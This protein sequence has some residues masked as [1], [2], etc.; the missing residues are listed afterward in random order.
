MN[1]EIV[2][3]GS[4]RGARNIIAGQIEE[5]TGLSTFNL[6]YPGSDIEFQE[7]L[8]RSLIHFNETPQ[9][10]L[11]AIDD[12]RQFLPSDLLIFRLERLYPLARYPYINKEM[13]ARGEKNISSKTLV[14]ARMNIRNFDIRRKSFT[15][16]DTITEYGS[17]P[18]YS[19]NENLTFNYDSLIHRYQ[20][21]NEL[22]YKVNSFLK[23]QK[24]CEENNIELTLVFSPNFKAHNYSFERR[25]KQ[26]THDNV[27]FI[28]YDSLNPIY[29]DE[30]YFYDNFH[31]RSAGAI[32]FTNEIVDF[33][34]SE[35]T[36]QLI[37]TN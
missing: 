2:I 35:K 14:L 15:Y 27:D 4:S 28:L 9:K 16:L 17:M 6:S 32:T 31:L 19:Q 29:K 21:N 13:I 23:I 1:K 3:L 12:P 33:L 5:A 34:E 30:A 24:I 22:E 18:I 25:M 11:L 20:T 37:N 7:F 8:L 36:N 26:L 10:V